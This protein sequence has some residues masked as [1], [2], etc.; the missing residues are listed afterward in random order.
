MRRQASRAS[1]ARLLD[2]AVLAG[3]GVGITACGHS[4]PTRYVTLNATPAQAPLATAA[5]APVQLGAV[6]IPA[7]LDRPE[8]VTHVAPNRLA[9]DDNDRWG[10][11][12]GQMMRSTLAQDLLP[13]LPPGAF[14]FPDA[15]A[16]AGTRT[17]VVT[18]LDC[19]ASAGGTLTLQVAWTLLAGQPART[20]M[21]QEAA[22]SAQVEGH[23]A[24][25]QAAALSRVLGELADRIA[26]SIAVR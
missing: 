19:N 8:V 13:R 12:L 5:M 2:A 24:A 4:A 10:A 15:P 23:D 21:S 9:V 18:V 25:A 7:V 20:T 16:P 14:V 17:L 11:P 26:A 6:H 3:I 22:L 1:I